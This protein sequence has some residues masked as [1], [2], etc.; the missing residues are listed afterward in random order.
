MNG[1][2]TETLNWLTAPDE[3]NITIPQ[4]VAGLV[5]ILVLSFLWSTVVSKLVEG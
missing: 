1:L 2:V 4:W 3:S 5:V